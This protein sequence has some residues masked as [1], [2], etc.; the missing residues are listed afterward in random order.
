MSVVFC[1][2]DMEVVGFFIAV[3]WEERCRADGGEAGDIEEWIP[4]SISLLSLGVGEDVG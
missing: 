3:F 1:G 4:R 2:V